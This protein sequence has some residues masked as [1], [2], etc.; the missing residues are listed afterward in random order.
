MQRMRTLVTAA[1][2]LTASPASAQSPF[3]GVTETA[4]EDG[5]QVKGQ[6]VLTLDGK[7]VGKRFVIR[8]PASGK[9]TARQAPAWN[10]SLVIGAHG[11][12]GGNS[13]DRAGKVFGT[14]VYLMSFHRR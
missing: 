1:L 14:M 3:I 13:V 8:V 5:R 9:A 10:G 2:L 11:G 6:V 4:V 12:S 7:P